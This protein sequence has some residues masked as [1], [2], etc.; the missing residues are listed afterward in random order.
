MKTAIFVSYCPIVH[1]LVNLQ[2][3]EMHQGKKKAVK[4][5]LSIFVFL[6]A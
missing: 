3:P 6:F 1:Q 4:S 5:L 2:T